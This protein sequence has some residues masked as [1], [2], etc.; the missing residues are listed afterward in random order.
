MRLSACC[1][2][3]PW[4][5][6]GDFAQTQKSRRTRRRR[7]VSVTILAAWWS[8]ELGSSEGVQVRC[9]I[10]AVLFC[11]SHFWHGGVRFHLMWMLDPQHEIV[12]SIGE[13]SCDVIA[14]AHAIER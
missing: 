6:L 4:S 10:A 7:Q 11:D 5:S 1:N 12:W 2:R 3:G 13:L 14:S 8:P 9:N